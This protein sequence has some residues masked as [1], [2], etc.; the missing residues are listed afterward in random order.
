MGAARRLDRGGTDEDRAE[1]GV[2]LPEA[3]RPEDAPGVGMRV[4]KGARSA[5]ELATELWRRFDT[6]RFRDALPLLSEDFEAHWPNTRERIRS[7]E[8]FIALN[9][10]YPGTWRCA[11]RRI[12]E[13]ADGVVTVTE[14]GDDRTSL[15]AVSFFR[16]R[17]GRIAAVEE[18]FAD[19]GPPPFDR[20][21]WTERY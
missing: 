10:S 5:R 3:C 9:E 2:E 11:V 19:N 21:A 15:F 7:R 16:V 12:E 6:G 13:C 4:M 1:R 18:Y 17:D 20:S 14:I 8:S